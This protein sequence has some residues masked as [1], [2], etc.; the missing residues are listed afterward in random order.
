MI[1]NK[2]EKKRIKTYGRSVGLHTQGRCNAP[3]INSKNGTFNPSQPPDRR[4][5]YDA[6]NIWVAHDH[7]KHGLLCS[8]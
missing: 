7:K 3:Y 8:V 2:R 1:R 6:V 5:V 4:C